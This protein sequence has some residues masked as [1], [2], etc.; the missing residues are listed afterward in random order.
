MP[1]DAKNR[2]IWKDSSAGCDQRREE[3][4]MTEDRWWDGSTGSI[5]MSFSNLWEI[6]KDREAWCAAVQSRKESDTTE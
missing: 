2:L 6:V 1:P 4:E 3:K 5:D